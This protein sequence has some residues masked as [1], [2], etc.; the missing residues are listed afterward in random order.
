MYC[1]SC[2]QALVAGQ[3]FCP[4]CGVATGMS[5]PV[6]PSGIPGWVPFAVADRRI[7]SL[8]VGWL[9]YAG[10]AAITG[11]IGLAFAHAALSGHMGP[12]GGFGH[13]MWMG[14]PFFFLHFA[15]VFLFL[16][17]GLALAAGVGLMQRTTWGRWVAII[18]GCLS[19]LHPLLGTAM[20]IW[21]LVVL[22]NASNAAAY[23]ATAR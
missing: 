8:A 21:T 19:L 12:W 20:G 14:P 10:L 5:I 23:E 18:A 1:N 11:F 6:A 7:H 2:G 16:R 3:G 17:V 22:L 15:R 13:R 4:R 9:V